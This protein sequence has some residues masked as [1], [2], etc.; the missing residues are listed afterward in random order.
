M[1]PSKKKQEAIREEQDW[2]KIDN[3]VIKSENFI[4]KYQKQI[5]IGIGAV[6][7]V[8]C[9]FMA[10]KYL[11][12]QPKNLEA[13]AAMFRGEQYFEQGKDSLALYGDGNEFVGFE[14]IANTYGSTTSGKLAKAYAGM[15]HAH[16][17]NYDSA[18]EYLESYSGSDELFTYQAKVV[19]GD[20]YV[21]KGELEKAVKLFETAAKKANNDL[22]SP[23]YYKKAALTYRELKNYDKVIELFTLIRN[24]YM[25][26][27]D[28]YDAARYIEEAKIL[29]QGA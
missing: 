17:G 8:V 3:A 20:C 13:Q 28:A 2:N 15:C 22:Y 18:I 23:I 12:L 25:N 5:L 21:N 29:K 6:V 10:Y 26:S 11:Y 19:L 4:E 14:E 7:L 9:L 27:R 1:A 24:N 16:M